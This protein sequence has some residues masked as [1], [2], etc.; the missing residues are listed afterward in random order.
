LDDDRSRIRELLRAITIFLRSH[1]ISKAI[2][3]VDRELRELSSD[4]FINEILEYARD[5]NVAIEEAIFVKVLTWLDALEAR[6]LEI[7]IDKKLVVDT[8][9][10]V[11]GIP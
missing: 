8:V 3:A 4:E 11:L 1:I 6:G 5:S 7:E 9:K 10:R 2:E